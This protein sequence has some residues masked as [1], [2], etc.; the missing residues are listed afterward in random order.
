MERDDRPYGDPPT[1]NG[2][3]RHD[4]RDP[5]RAGAAT[6][7]RWATASGSS[8]TTRSATG[9]TPPGLG[10]RCF[11]LDVMTYGATEGVMETLGA[12]VRFDEDQRAP[13]RPGRLSCRPDVGRL[14]ALQHCGDDR[15]RCH[16][17]G[18]IAG[19]ERV[20]GR[21]STRPRRSR[22]AASWSSTRRCR[23]SAGW[24]EAARR[25]CTRRSTSSAPVAREHLAPRRG[26]GRGVGRPQ[27]RRGGGAG[28]RRTASAAG[29]AGA[30]CL[31]RGRLP[32]HRRGVCEGDGSRSGSAPPV[33]ARRG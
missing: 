7:S 15:G 32:G 28:A 10:P 5:E 13:R 26:G 18:R 19:H 33:T 22:G 1:E 11:E 3:R 17:P 8:A 29:S 2:D 23:A 9:R 20:A 25:C 12:R 4:R 31:R 21:R 24:R 6:T 30:T 16:R 14:A 27:R